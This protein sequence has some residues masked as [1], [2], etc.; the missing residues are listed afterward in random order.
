MYNVILIAL[1][2]DGDVIVKLTVDIDK[3][4]YKCIKLPFFE[5]LPWGHKN[6]FGV[7]I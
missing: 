3:V 6:Y 1:V 2:G 7:L 5:Y 4:N